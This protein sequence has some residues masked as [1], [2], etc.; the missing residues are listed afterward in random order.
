MTERTHADNSTDAIHEQLERMR[1]QDVQDAPGKICIA[2]M[3]ENNQVAI[4]QSMQAVQW[5]DLIELRLDAMAEYDLPELIREK[6][7][8]LIITNRPKRQGGAAPDGD[9]AA[10]VKPLLEAVELGVD[11]VDFEFD[12]IEHIPASRGNTKI[13]ISHHDFQRVP[14][15]F[16]DIH[17]R[18]IDAG[19]DI[20]KIAVTTQ[21]LAECIRVLDLAANVEHPTIAVAMGPTGIPSRI[22]ARR[23]PNIYLTYAALNAEQ[24]GGPGQLTAWDMRNTYRAELI[25]ADTK[26][27][28]LLA[29]KAHESPLLEPMNNI[30][31]TGGRAAAFL[32]LP[33][34]GNILDLLRPLAR[35]GFIGL[36]VDR[37]ICNELNNK[38][39]RL[40][41]P[42]KFAKRADVLFC[43]EGTWQADYVG[44]PG[45]PQIR[46]ALTAWGYTR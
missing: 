4:E 2:L 46:A 12:A 35:H 33:C 16:E 26:L 45:E 37:G 25:D 15:N 42:M 3:P 17:Q 29:P 44:T 5:G 28:G 39:R 22:L 36:L 27:Y 21:S 24:V 10:R 34:E 38:L 41:Q 43:N 7:C 13:I 40:D 30:L 1:K 32:P 14:D 11:H 19:A 8:P 31:R 9:E 18:M 6:L 23:Y 20:A